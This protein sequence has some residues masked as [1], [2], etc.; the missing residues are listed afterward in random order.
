MEISNTIVFRFDSPE[1]ASIFYHSFMPEFH[2]IPMKR[3]TWDMSSPDP[4]SAE[5]SLQIVSE[6]ATA[7][8]ATINSVLIFAHVVEKTLNLIFDSSIQSSIQSSSKENS[9]DEK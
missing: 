3:S 1:D 7:F 4:T 2:S 9:L 5:I 6:D 8:R